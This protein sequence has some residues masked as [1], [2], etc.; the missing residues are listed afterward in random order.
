MYPAPLILCLLSAL[1]LSCAQHSPIY[2]GWGEWVGPDVT[3]LG[4][5]LIAT[6]DW[7]GTPGMITT[8]DENH[9]GDGYT[10]ARLAPGR[11]VIEYAYYTAEF[12]AHPMGKIELDL[13]PGHVYAIGLQLCYWC[14]PRKYAV[15]VDDRTSGGLIWGKRP[16]W[17]SW[18]L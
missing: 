18:Y 14:H 13:A 11:H 10:M 8:I 4:N 3:G 2:R 9:L 5:D 12:G 15:W 7:S 17:P 6:F 16:D 1:T